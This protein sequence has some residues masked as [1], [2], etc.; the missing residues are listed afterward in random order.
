MKTNITKKQVSSLASKDDLKPVLKGALYEPEKSR[1][2]VTNGYCIIS[3][4]VSADEN[5]SKGILPTQLFK[6]KISDKCSYEINGVAKRIDT[7]SE[8][9]FN[10]I[11]DKYPDY[12]SVI[13]DSINNKH[14]VVLNLEQLHLLY[15]AALKDSDNRKDIKLTFNLDD[16]NAVIKFEQFAS[17]G[18]VNAGSPAYNGVIMPCRLN[19]EGSK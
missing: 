8:A 4:K 13:P 19:N 16:C 7:N 18:G 6:S 14:E 12:E 2:T 1:L 9:V 15:N 5:D 17:G 3:Y 10:L 11:D